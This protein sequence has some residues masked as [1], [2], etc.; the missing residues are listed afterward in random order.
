MIAQADDCTLP[1]RQ[2][3]EAMTTVLEFVNVAGLCGSVLVQP[4]PVRDG[5][6]VT[7]GSPQSIMAHIIV[8][9]FAGETDQAVSLTDYFTGII[10]VYDVVVNEGDAHPQRFVR[11]A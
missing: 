11:R 9:S 10:T 3:R 4:Q 2:A 7:F 5:Y 8:V 1:M 6:A